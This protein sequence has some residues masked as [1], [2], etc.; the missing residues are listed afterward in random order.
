MIYALARK[1]V[2]MALKMSD[3][4]ELKVRVSNFGWSPLPI[5]ILVRFGPIILVRPKSF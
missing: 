4:R 1:M 5:E 2:E 3:I